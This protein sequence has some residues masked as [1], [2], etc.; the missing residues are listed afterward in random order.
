MLLKTKILS[1]SFLF[2]SALPVIC[3]VTFLVTA[4]INAYQME[5][6]LEQSY[7]Q[8]I[9]VSTSELTWLEKGKEV[10]INGKLFDVKSAVVFKDK[11]RLTGLFDAV[12][13]KLLEDIN[14]LEENDDPSSP[15]CLILAQM[16]CP[17]ILQHV[18]CDLSENLIFNK[19]KFT[20]ILSALHSNPFIG[21]NT[22]PPNSRFFHHSLIS[23]S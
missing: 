10:L 18:N 9:S 6:K 11:T 13:D 21:I 12:E 7:L 23:V 2:L 1:V 14:A 22:P 4:T 19:L 3:S 8:T 20:D 15:V 5:E 16:F 17:A